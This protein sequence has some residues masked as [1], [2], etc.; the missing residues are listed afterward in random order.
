[1]AYI[2]AVDLGSSN[3]KILLG[4]V[5]NG[6]LTAEEIYRFD[7]TPAA[8]GG[9][10][11]WDWEQICAEVIRGLRLAAQ[12]APEK[13]I[14]VSCDS[15]AQDFGLLDGSGKLLEAPRCY[16]DPAFTAAVPLTSVKTP[17]EELN[18][19]AICTS[20]ITTLNQL[21]W[22]RNFDPG[23]LKPCR[24]ILH[25][26]DLLHRLLGGTVTGD[27]TLLGISQLFDLR[28]GKPD[29]PLLTTLG[30]DPAIVPA[31]AA[32]II[33]E[34]TH[35]ELKELFPGTK[36]VAGVGHDT[37]AAFYG[38]QTK[39]DELFISLGSWQMSGCMLPNTV[40]KVTPPGVLLT[41]RERQTGFFTGGNGMYLVQRCCAK[42]K[43]EPEAFS[44][45]ALDAEAENSEC[46]GRFDVDDPD[47]SDPAA[48]FPALIRRKIIAGT[49]PVSRG[50]ILRS[51]NISLA[52]AIRETA[53]RLSAVRGRE[54]TGA[55]MVSG[56]IRNRELV[57]N[58]TARTGLPLRCGEQESSARGNLLNIAA[59]MVTA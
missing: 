49:V 37:A 59:A 23:T 20:P 5:G 35:P 18:V 56:G 52:D 11:Y 33:G 40:K 16:R 39:A 25:I 9:A 29:L 53:V 30:L 7:H 19:N 28:T 42:W 22:R 17:D 8:R 50:D 24:K 45:A 34:I 14:A 12:A 54:F 3:G 44:F 31:A 15:W 32:G 21:V 27:P 13:I 55:V 1:M 58:F 38:A 26:A 46:D 43:T 57:A 41:L 6:D 51:I 10:L 48:D 2:A 36:I 4:R 47:F